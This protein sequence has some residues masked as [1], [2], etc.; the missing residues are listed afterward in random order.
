MPRRY[1][2]QTRQEA[3]AGARTRI[4]EA[5]LDEVAAA[6]GG[7]VTLHAVAA[8][9]GVALRTLYNHFAGR[10]ELLAAAFLHH[11]ARTR[12]AVDAVA[13]PD[14]RPHEQLQHVLEAYHGRYA[15]MGDRL[16]V[17]LSMRGFPDLE[18]QIRIIRRQRRRLLEEIVEHAE[19]AGVLKLPPATAVAL[20]YTLTGHAGW[21]SL[22]E[23]A[24][25][26]PDEATRLA[27]EALRSALFHDDARAAGPMPAP[28][29]SGGG[30]PAGG[31]GR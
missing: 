12:A 15:E 4:L 11:A 29:P 27:I 14:A 26:N 24:D 20:A 21:Q 9:A 1:S 19:R 2:M 22:R 13:L 6:G 16:S 28:D 5:A 18:E 25:G 7:G 17:L 8:R 31:L 30:L 10:D 3:A 23:Q